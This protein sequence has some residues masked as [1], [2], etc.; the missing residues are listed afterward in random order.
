[1]GVLSSVI[2]D[3]ISLTPIT[4]LHLYMRRTNSDIIDM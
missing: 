3:I 1:M 4:Y 2:T